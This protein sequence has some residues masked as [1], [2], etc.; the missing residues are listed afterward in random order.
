[1]EKI[2]AASSVVVDLTI[3]HSATMSAKDERHVPNPNATYEAGYAQ[4]HHHHEKVIHV[5][6][7]EFGG[8]KH[9]PFDL[10]HRR[11]LEYTGLSGDSSASQAARRKARD[12]LS[13]RL[14]KALLPLV[15]ASEEPPFEQIWPSHGPACIGRINALLAMSKQTL[16][17][18]FCLFLVF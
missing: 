13:K 12:E 17:L 5:M 11:V 9:L 6:N 3:V 18:T 7:S 1:M 15:S 2:R 14:K 10:S 4:R 8:R 16:I